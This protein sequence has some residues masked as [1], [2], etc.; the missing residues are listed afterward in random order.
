MTIG[1]Y[2]VAPLG[3]DLRHF[4]RNFL[5]ASALLT[6]RLSKDLEAAHGITLGEFGVLVQ[7]A[8]HPGNRMRMAAIAEAMCFTRSRTTQILDRLERDGYA[9]RDR[10]ET[11]GRGVFATLTAQGMDLVNRAAPSHAE[12]AQSLFFDHFSAEEVARLGRTFGKVIEGLTAEP[13]PPEE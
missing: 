7:L 3:D 9:V 11:D 13:L 4:W 8:R 6:T 2:T 5:T 12:T 10:S 1:G